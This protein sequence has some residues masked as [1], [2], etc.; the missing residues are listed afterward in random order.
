MVIFV[1]SWKMYYGSFVTNFFQGC[2]RFFVR[3]LIDPP[4][5]QIWCVQF[6]HSFPCA[7]MSYTRG[8]TI[9]LLHSRS[10]PEAVRRLAVRARPP[11]MLLEEVAGVLKPVGVRTRRGFGLLLAVAI[12]LTG[13]AAALDD[14][15][16]ARLPNAQ[17]HGVRPRG[18]CI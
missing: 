17:R 12:R 5:I 18:R 7:M 10:R 11:E 15:S 8:V 16:H 2:Q 6:S 13:H 3:R 14:L 1:G 9:G 4:S